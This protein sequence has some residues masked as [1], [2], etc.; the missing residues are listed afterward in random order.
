MPLYEYQ[1]PNCGA[2]DRFTPV[3]QAAAP[4]ACPTCQ[5]I[6]P[7]RLSVPR[8]SAMSPVQLK[9]AARNERSRHAPHVCR[10]GCGCRGHASRTGAAGA[11]APAAPKRQAYKG[12]RP[13]V[14]EHR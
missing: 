7:R 6:S 10:S 8:V 3:A 1:C 5:T 4:A 13:W 12:P 14:I 2:F 9:A 11:T